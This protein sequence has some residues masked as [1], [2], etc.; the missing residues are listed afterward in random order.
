VNFLKTE[1]SI[2]NGQSRASHDRV[3]GVI[4]S[5]VLVMTALEVK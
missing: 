2:Y 5:G 4:V 3:K 1:V